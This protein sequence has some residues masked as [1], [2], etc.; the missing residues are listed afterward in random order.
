MEIFAETLGGNYMKL[1]KYFIK[2]WKECEIFNFTNT[3]NKII[4]I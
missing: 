3:D 4:E 1:L 2:Y